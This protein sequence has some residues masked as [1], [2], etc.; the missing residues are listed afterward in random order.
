LSGRA[1]GGCARVIST[2]GIRSFKMNYTYIVYF[3]RFIPSVGLV[4]NNT[5]RHVD[6]KHAERYADNMMKLDGVSNVRIMRLE[7]V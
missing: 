3:D 2:N 5:C 1:L 4:T 7:M 6:L